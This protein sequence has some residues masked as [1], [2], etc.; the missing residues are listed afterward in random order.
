MSRSASDF[1]PPPEKPVARPP[2]SSVTMSDE[3]RSG[4]GPA[5]LIPAPTLTRGTHDPE[6]EYLAGERESLVQAA[7]KRLPGMLREAVIL[8]DYEGLSHEEIAAM[9]KIQPAAQRKR[10]SRALAALGQMLKGKIE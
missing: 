1:S 3:P 9:A 2:D 4:P 10:Y 8:H 5:A 7:V 6:R